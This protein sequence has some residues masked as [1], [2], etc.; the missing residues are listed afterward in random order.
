MKRLLLLCLTY[1]MCA[2]SHQMAAQKSS[3]NLGVFNSLAIGV[4]ASTTGIGIDLASPIGNHLAI[5]AGISFMPNFSYST[6]V[7]VDVNI[8]E[9]YA[10]DIP[11]NIEVE[12]E[13]GRTAGEILLNVYPFKS[14]SFFLCGGAYFGGDKLIKIK[15]HSDELAGLIEEGKDAGIEIGDYRIPVDQN[16]DISG[17]LKVASF[18]PYVGLGFGRAVPKKRVGF[19]FE[20]GVQFHKTPEVYTNNGDLSSL[21]AEADNDFSDIID[22]LTVYPVLKFRL[23]GKIF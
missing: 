1:M 20:M 9:P 14:A 5:R 18:R 2:G 17:G 10:G 12:G 15:G 11:S 22:K 16:G 7:D 8:D 23:C 4:S 21:A 19:M 6:D 13:M 3:E